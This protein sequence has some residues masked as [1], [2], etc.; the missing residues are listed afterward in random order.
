MKAE[1]LP[2][3]DALARL[4][5]QRGGAGR[6]LHQPRRDG[7]DPDAVGAQQRGHP[8]GDLVEC[9]LGHAVDRGRAIGR[10]RRLVDD[11]APG[12]R[13]RRSQRLAEQQRRDRVDRQEALPARHVERVDGGVDRAIGEAGV[14]VEHVD[15]RE[16]RQDRGG[17]RVDL[18]FLRQVD[19]VRGAGAAGVADQP[20]GLGQTLGLDVE[21]DQFG[22]LAR[23]TQRQP[24][25]EPGRRTGDDHDF[26]FVPPCHRLSPIPVFAPDG[27][28]SWEGLASASPTRSPKIAR[29]A[30]MVTSGRATDRRCRRRWRACPRCPPLP[31][32]APRGCARC[33]P[34]SGAR[35]R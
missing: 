8:I 19:A 26:A 31:A 13:Q 32:P 12:G 1:H 28:A 35:C 3:L 27:T 11:A 7:I 6:R 22:A 9:R 34:R 2:A 16:R 15:A 30:G 21:R 18:G 29:A 20:R 24:A 23:I 14:V 5:R 25:S 17:D 33:G 4:G 10:H